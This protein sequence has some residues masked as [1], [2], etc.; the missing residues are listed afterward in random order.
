[1]RNGGNIN[2]PKAHI[3][4]STGYFIKNVSIIGKKRQLRKEHPKLKEKKKD[5][6]KQESTILLLLDRKKMKI[7]TEV[8]VGC[9][10]KIKQKKP[11][12]LKK[13]RG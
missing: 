8:S 3:K 6:A 12:R 4:N 1:M 13:I 5:I 9:T 7:Y 2:S 10:S 11:T